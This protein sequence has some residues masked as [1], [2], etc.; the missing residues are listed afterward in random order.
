MTLETQALIA[1]TDDRNFVGAEKWLPEHFGNRPESILIDM[2][3]NLET[4]I[5]ELSLD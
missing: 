2:H 1:S 4:F 3:L 5:G